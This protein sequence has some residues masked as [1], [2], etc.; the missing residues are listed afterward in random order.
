MV[1]VWSSNCTQRSTKASSSSSISSKSLF[2]TASLVS[3]HNLSAGISS[4]EPVGSNSRCIPSGSWTSLLL[5]AT[6]PDPP[7]KVR[8]SCS[9]Q[10]P[11]LFGELIESHREQL[12]VDCGQDQPENLSAFGPHKAVEV[13]PLVAS[14][15]GI[16]LQVSFPPAPTPASSEALDPAEPRPRPRA[17]PAAPPDKPS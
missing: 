10:L 9:L 17:R 13:G 5:C 14:L 11:P 12:H 2:A 6:Q 16:G 15:L 3:G 7:P 4:G 8:A 1:S